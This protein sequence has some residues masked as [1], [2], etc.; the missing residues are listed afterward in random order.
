MRSSNMEWAD[1]IPS[2]WQFKIKR[3]LLAVEVPP[4][5]LHT[6]LPDLRH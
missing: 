3:N 1:F 2:E 6:W 5:E 4:K